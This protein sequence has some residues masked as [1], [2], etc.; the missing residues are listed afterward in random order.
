MISN[1]EEESWYY[2]AVKISALL[3]VAFIT[4]IAFILLEQKINLNCMNNYVKI[5]LLS[6]L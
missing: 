1:E 2:I 3:K 6:E 4:W 5:K